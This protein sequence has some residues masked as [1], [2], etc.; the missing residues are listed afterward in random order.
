MYNIGLFTWDRNVIHITFHFFK[1]LNSY[2][3]GFKWKSKFDPKFWWKCHWKFL[4]MS[5]KFYEQKIVF[6]FLNT[7]KMHKLTSS[8]FMILIKTLLIRE[9]TFSSFVFFSKIISLTHIS[10][11]GHNFFIKATFFVCILLR[12]MF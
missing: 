12:L 8:N 4:K 1:K 7:V 6:V 10:K 2:F 9:R 5:L 3:F 11:E